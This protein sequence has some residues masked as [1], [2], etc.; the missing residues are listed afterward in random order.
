MLSIFGDDARLSRRAMLRI[1]GLGL[2]GFT[3]S[4]LL[5]AQA[6]S[7]NAE[8]PFTTGKSVIFLLQQG[9]PSQHETFDPKVDAPDAVRTV[10]GATQTSVPGTAFGAAMS[11][12][13]KH[14]DKLAVVR[15][16]STGNG[17]HNIQPLVG[18][19]SQNANIGAYFARLVGANNPTTGMPTNVLLS[20]KAVE[21]NGMGPDE[22]FGNLQSAGDLGRGAEAFS[23]GGGSA[24]QKDMQL[25]LSEDRFFDRRQLLTTLDRLR[26]DVDSQGGIEGVEKFRQQAYEMVLKGVADAFDFSKEDPRTI[27]RYDTSRYLLPRP[28]YEGRS[29]GSK[30]RMWYQ[31][32]ART[33]GKLLLLA[34]RLCEAGCGFVTVT[35]RFVWDMHA[36][37]NNL[38][39]ERGM[40]AVGKPFDHAVAAF[41]EDCQ[42]R[43]LSDDILL[44]TSGEMGRTPKINARGGRDHWGRLTPLMMYGGGITNGQ[45]IGQS[46]RDGGEPAVDPYN[47]SNLISTIMHT[48]FDLGEVRIRRELPGDA[49]RFRSIRHTDSRV[50][51]MRALLEMSEIVANVS[52]HRI[53]SVSIFAFAC[54][55]ATSLLAGESK[56]LNVVIAHGPGKGQLAKFAE[57]LEANYNVECSFIE[58]EK[59]KRLKDSEK[60]TRNDIQRHRG[61][62]RLRRYRVESLPH[63]GARR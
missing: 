18:K 21:P 39:V 17:G 36:D 63:L 44:V 22:R 23:P 61:A 46:T 60:Y 34:R 30:D 27:E 16:F 58:A 11:Q 12:L 35:T 40:E 42:Q 38:G 3:L 28:Y 8:K 9:G 26:R 41:I 19:A 62:R 49:V 13:S 32:N 2:G 53:A 51:V 55:A 52:L 57:H 45:L 20:G 37:K 47:T 15:S 43:G 59:S 48:L 6:L 14:A 50:A 25:S 1:G 56:P 10:G 54:L 4:Q 5:A 29:N 31:S 7:A 33:L 24:L